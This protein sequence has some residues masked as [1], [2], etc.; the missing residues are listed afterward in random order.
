[1]DEYLGLDTPSACRSTHRG[2][3][4]WFIEW[5]HPRESLASPTIWAA[6]GLRAACGTF[7]QSSLSMLNTAVAA[8]GVKRMDASALPSPWRVR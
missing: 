6:T 5:T 8:I 3:H 4:M 1:M 7:I 2:F